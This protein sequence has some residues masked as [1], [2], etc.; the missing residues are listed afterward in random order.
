VVGLNRE[1]AGERVALLGGETA[2]V[3]LGVKESLTLWLGHIPKLAEGAGDL[4][5]TVGREAG[6]LLDRVANLLTLR[7]AEAGHSFVVIQE[8]L[9]LLGRH[10]VELCEAVAQPLLGFGGETAEAGLALERFLLLL[11]SEIAMALHPL[12]EVRPVSGMIH[13]GGVLP[14]HMESREVSALVAFR[15][16]CLRRKMQDSQHQSRKH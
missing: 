6:K 2:A 13:A 7:R 4:V 12:L 11:R 3:A 10:V 8:S 5:A 14:G 1:E 16:L 15:L 9:A